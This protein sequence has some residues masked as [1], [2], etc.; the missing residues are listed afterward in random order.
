MLD[1][2]DT[3][4]KLLLDDPSCRTCSE[5]VAALYGAGRKSNISLLS[6]CSS[7]ESMTTSVML[8]HDDTDYKF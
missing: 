4:Y 7:H 6:R 1:H 3:D 2:D 5:L 8:D